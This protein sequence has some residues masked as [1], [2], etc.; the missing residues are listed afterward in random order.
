M[1]L[2]D[3]CEAVARWRDGCLEVEAEVV[4]VGV[5]FAEGHC[6]PCVASW[7]PVPC[8]PSD[9]P[10]KAACSISTSQRSIMRAPVLVLAKATYAPDSKLRRRRSRIW[11]ALFSCGEAEESGAPCGEIKIEAWIRPANH[12]ICR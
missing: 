12:G 8:L 4:A 7:A 5:A 6:N 2:V 1:F 9:R 3:T 11:R 10:N